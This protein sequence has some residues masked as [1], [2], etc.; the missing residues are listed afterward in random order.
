MSFF[1]F[2]CQKNLFI[3]CMISFIHVTTTVKQCQ[4]C[5][6]SHF[7]LASNCSLCVLLHCPQPSTEL[8]RG[9]QGELIC[10][11][12]PSTCIHPCPGSL[13]RERHTCS[14]VQLHEITTGLLWGDLG[15]PYILSQS[16][17][18]H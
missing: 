15:G 12:A 16:H 2:S 5:P 8:Q 10:M 14:C 17:H 9:H 7:A 13:V 11:Q 1:A 4:K 18:K 6:A 3:I